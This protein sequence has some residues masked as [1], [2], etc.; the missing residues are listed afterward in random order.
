MPPS[1]GLVV[2]AYRPNARRLAAYVRTLDDRLDPARIRVELDAPAAGVADALADL[3]A[4]IN[5]VP[6]RRGKGAAITCGFER[7]DT[8]VLAFADADGSTPAESVAEVVAPLTAGRADLSVGSRRHPGAE[9]LSHQTFARRWLGDAFAWLARRLLT[10]GL[11]DY[12]CGAKAITR[13]AW[14][15]VRSHLYESGFAW[16]V[17]LVAMAGALDC[18]IEEVPVIWDDKPGSTVDTLDTVTELLRAL[19]AVRHRAKLLADYPLHSAIAARRERPDAL[20]DRFAT[21]DPNE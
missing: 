21:G 14:G 12:Q 10:V 16:D 11:Y 2:P 18:R 20:V 7:L 3:P 19:L 1:V 5:A 17:E 6:E 8:D 15:R 9:V 4:T 13:D